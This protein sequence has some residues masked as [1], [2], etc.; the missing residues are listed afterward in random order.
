MFGRVE[1]VQVGKLVAQ[2]VAQHA[3]GLGHFADALFADDDVVAE[4]LRGDPEPDNVRAPL[5]YVGLRC[6]RLFITAL[7]LLA[8]GNLLAVGIHHEAVGQHGLEGRR[9]VAR[10]RQQQG[11][12]K[13]AA[14]LVAALQVHV[15]LPG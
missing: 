2:G 15:G 9:A 10:Q 14:M 12:L 7:A 4:V 13:P 5:L 8:L 1:V 11:G 3:V 6:L